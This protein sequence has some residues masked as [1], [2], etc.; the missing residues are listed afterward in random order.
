M[1]SLRYAILGP[2]R[3]VH[4]QGQP[5]KAAKPRQL[6]ATLLLHP[7]RFVSTG[8]IA[9]ALWENSPPRSATA[10]IRTYVRQLRGV[11]QEA[12]LPAPIDTSAS[13]YSIEVGVDEL[14]ASLFESLLAEGGHLRDAGDGRQAMQVLSRAYNLWRGRPLEDLAMPA[15]WEGSISRLEAQHRGLVDVLLDLRLEYGDASGAAV[16]LNARLTDDPYD[17]QL[18][19]RLV[20]ALIAAGRVGEARAAYQKAVQT[21][22]DELDIKPGPE[23]EAAGAR[24]ENGRS[25]NW[26]NPGIP[27]ARTTERADPE[28]QPGPMAAPEL[29][30][31]QRPPSQLPL[32]LA[33]FSGRQANLEQLRDLVCGRDPVRP[34]IAVISGAPGTGKTSLAVRLGHLVREYFPDGQI[35]LDMHG[36]TQPRDPAAALTDLLLSLN[37]PD[38]AI[39]TDP[40][41]RSAMLRS[42]LAS[43]RVLIIL[44]DVATAGQVTPL[45][46]GTGASAVVVT[47][48]N[49]L[50]DLA[51][52]DSMPLDTF[53]DQEAA[54]LLSSVAG[55]GRIDAA[56]P[57][58]EEILEACANLPL[59]IR[60]VG[61]RLAQRPDL[62]ARELARR[63]RDETS[64]LDELSIGELAVRTSADLSY[65]ALSPEEQRLY[66][67]IGHFAV[68]VFSARALEAVASPASVRRSLDRLIE[69]NLV[70][71]SSVDHRGT[72][73]YRVH[74][75]LRLHAL[76]VGN[77][78]QKAQAVRDVETVL[79]AILNKIRRANNA[80]TFEYFGV[81][82][83][84]GPLTAPDPSPFTETDAIAWFDSERSTFV[85]AIR[86]AAQNGLHEYAWRIA[87]AWGPYL[88]MRA[89]FDDWNGSHQQGLLSAVAVGDRWGEAIMHRNL[90]QLALYQDDWDPAYLH[91]DAAA[92][93]FAET[94]DR[95]GEGIAATG[96]G[97]WL[98]ERGRPD[99][100]L[101]QYKKA[102]EAFVEV[103]NA[104]AEAL[105][106]TA[107]ANALLIRGDTDAA[108]RYLAQAFLLAA[109]RVDSHR[110]AKVRRRIAA[111]RVRQ[112]RHDQAIRQLRKSLAIFNG[113]G[114]DHCAAYALADLGQALAE[115]GEVAAARKMLLDAIDLGH[116]LGDRSVEGQA[117]QHLGQLYL[118]S[119]NVD[120]ARR[121]LERA[122][123]VWQQAAND[124][125]AAECRRLLTTSST[126]AATG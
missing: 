37:L 67:L 111:L 11:L 58:A 22:A 2:L 26:P 114:D 100:G 103:G 95:L 98:R 29:Q 34:P 117:A 125:R 118:S 123:R 115:R 89:G 28:P 60:I 61:S 19:R 106:R 87:A 120:S 5:L 56:S 49:R 45:M 43:R 17:E 85:P 9:D 39:P 48:R 38:F 4:V 64:R 86:A 91:F 33:D 126:G 13:G 23:L 42:E 7:N 97:T 119:G 47:S 116:R 90:G 30:E 51:G 112:D 35:Y 55:A 16:L 44:D 108:A 101:A 77:D 32:D 20:D 121:T 93:A 52:A 109:R 31:P 50:M 8:L 10:N 124:A 92:Q 88:D 110:E 99:E 69:V 40:E 65:G 75:L 102:I 27:A 84:S 74:D 83:H 59:A 18:W 53:D 76:G 94:G 21:L 96:L 78:E 70:R 73:R 82:E 46:P 3:L 36:A 24:A 41:R 66:R 57:E 12:G 79:D 54:V 81:L 25:A 113:I 72:A 104:N 15:A 63:L 105:A 80:L 14:D 71:I 122:A 68:G 62:S 107:T 1:D 6:L